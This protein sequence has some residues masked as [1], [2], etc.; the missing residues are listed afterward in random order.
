MRTSASARR[1]AFTLIEILVVIGIIAVLIGILIPTIEHARH[2][3]YKDK[4]ASNLRQIAQAMGIYGT[5]NHNS[6]PRTIYIPGQPIT[7]GTG[8]TAPDPFT[9]GAGGVAPND[10]TAAVF[11]L[12]VTQKLPP[13]IFI[14]PYNDETTFS[15]DAAATPPVAGRSNF[16]DY[17]KNLAYSIANPYPSTAAVAAGYPLK[18]TASAELP[19]AADLNPGVNPPISD[20]L[21]VAP[22]ASSSQMSKALSRN[23]E[24]DGQNVLYNDG[25][26]AWHTDPFAGRGGDNIY[27]TADGKVDAS[28]V[29]VRDTIL[30]PP[31]K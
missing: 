24:R 18:Q 8:A 6:F 12:L 4:C 15:T 13:E 23:H 1:P 3:A 14:C 19:V 27:T 9:G 2:Q 31:V 10:V 17:A 29:D 21:S 7:Y 22:G 30:L 25:H 20:V 26:V 16:T 28:P 5:E 11:L